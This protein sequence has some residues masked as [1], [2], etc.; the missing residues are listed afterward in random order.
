VWM[1]IGASYP[2]HP[3]HAMQGRT[4][5]LDLG[6]HSRLEGDVDA[7]R[8]SSRDFVVGVSPHVGFDLLVGPV[9]PLTFQFTDSALESLDLGLCP[10][11]AVW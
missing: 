9:V 1:D 8:E 10:L 2:S 6:D 5:L 4:E 11:G 7:R 3:D